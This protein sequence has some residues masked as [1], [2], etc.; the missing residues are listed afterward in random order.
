MRIGKVGSLYSMMKNGKV[1]I[2]GVWDKHR[3]KYCPDVQTMDEQGFKGMSQQYHYNAFL[4]PKGTPRPII[5]IL[6]NVIKKTVNTEEAKKR[7]HG[8]ALTGKFMGPDELAVFLK[9]SEKIMGELM[10]E[11]K[12]GLK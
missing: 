12:R 8:V 6:S 4:A 7:L 10:L 5:N 11:A 9:D 2:I 3:S 1:R